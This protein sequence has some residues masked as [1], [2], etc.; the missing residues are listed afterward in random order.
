MTLK[1]GGDEEGAPT[2]ARHSA[3]DKFRRGVLAN[4]NRGGENVAT[5]ALLGALLGAQCG[6]SGI[7]ADLLSGL[8]RA[9]RE[10]LDREIDA[11]VAAV[12]LARL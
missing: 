2:S 3:T 5:G 4:A 11:F 12:P 7:P 9:Q 1:Y 6:Y 10:R 8:A